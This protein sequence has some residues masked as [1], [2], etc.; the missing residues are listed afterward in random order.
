MASVYAIMFLFGSCTSTTVIGDDPEPAP[1][2]SIGKL[3]IHLTTNGYTRANTEDE[4]ETLHI[5][6]YKEDECMG[7]EEAVAGDSEYT[8]DVPATPGSR[9]DK[10]VAFANLGAA[11]VANINCKLSSLNTVIATG[12]QTEGKG[13]VM[14]SSRCFDTNGADMLATAISDDNYEKGSPVAIALDRV[15]T[16]VSLTNEIKVNPSVDM[17]K[18]ATKE[19]RK[20]VLNLEGWGLS[21]VEQTSYLVK[22]MTYKTG[23]ELWTDWNKDNVS[24]WA[25]S[26]SWDK[27]VS[28]P[29][30][31]ETPPA[32]G[33]A[34]KYPKY[35]ELTNG[36]GNE[37][38]EHET[39][40][41]AKDYTTHNAVASV[42][43][44]GHYTLDG[45]AQTFYRYGDGIYTEEELWEMLSHQQNVVFA[46]GGV[47]K[48]SA[49]D[50]KKES[51][52][53]NVAGKPSN[54]FTIQFDESSEL[55]LYYDK[56]GK[57]LSLD[58]LVSLNE[59]LIESVGYV[60]KFESGKCVFIVP[61]QHQNYL[62]DAEVQAE[63]AY[64]LVR[65]HYYNLTLKSIEGMG[66]GVASENDIVLESDY[67]SSVPQYKVSIT[68][69]VNPWTT[70]NQNI[71]I[72]K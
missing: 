12:L 14:A 70:L 29:V 33:Y 21:A 2:Q 4:V 69:N 36:F 53:V 24:H 20:L 49:A 3:H 65:N 61:I 56:S 30:A 5:A 67:G 6:F 42:I 47:A 40:R 28:F 55:S 18:G 15:A 32:N 54:L 1:E 48:C 50:L 66:T 27:T 52:L 22:Q 43:I 11:D 16:K 46:S 31:G 13:F 57:E 7:I 51:R 19:T 59:K 35:S 71:D 10:I 72:K 63:G 64:G 23:D 58:N 34:L 45:T 37:V 25:H 38:F 44:K 26:V 41:P 39:T 9:P 17:K 8:V 68:V 62:A 60:E